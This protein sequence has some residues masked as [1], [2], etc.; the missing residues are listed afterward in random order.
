M[1]CVL[2][3]RMDGEQWL[4][5]FD[6]LSIFLKDFDDC[7]VDVIFDFVYQFYCF[8]DVDDLV[9]FDCIFRI[10]EGV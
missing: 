2:L 6:C 10:Y 5:E 4:V 3:G 8:D 9:F 7:V 1:G